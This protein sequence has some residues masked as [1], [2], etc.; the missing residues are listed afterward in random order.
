MHFLKQSTASQNVLLGPFVDDSD[1]V[2][3]ETAL[4]IANT[5]IKIWKGG[6]TLVGK[7]S[8]GATHISVGNYY[9]TL[10]ATDT[11]TLGRM[12]I[13]VQVTG[14]L[15]VRREFM[16][17]PANIYDSMVSGTDL[18]DV[19]V[20]QISGSSVS[21]SSAQLGVNVV[22]WKGSSAPAMTGD[23]YAR[24]GAP[25]GAS[26]SADVAAIKSDTGSILTDTNELQGDWSDVTTKLLE[27]WQLQGLDSGNA[28][29]VTPTSREAGS[30][31][32]VISGDGTTTTTVTRS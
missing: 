15:P 9:A 29:T 22:N 16:V 7:N 6:T 1:G 21:T 17:L 25:A 30:I 26:V 23:S 2:T 20:T 4:S 19:S 8:G 5:D 28:M 27:L 32:Q 11:N 13:I 31:S 24:L 14:A 3:A 18:F 10:D 12:E